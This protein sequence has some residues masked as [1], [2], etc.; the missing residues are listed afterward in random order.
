MDCLH[1]E[2]MLLPDDLV[3]LS[4]RAQATLEPC[5]LAAMQAVPSPPLG[6]PPEQGTGEGT[7]PSW[8]PR[9]C[10]PRSLV[11]GGRGWCAG[12][13][14]VAAPGR[15]VESGGTSPLVRRRTERQIP[16]LALGQPWVGAVLVGSGS[17]R[18]VAPPWSRGPVSP[19]TGGCLTCV[20]FCPILP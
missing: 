11:A 7:S 9:P 12:L 19:S 1:Q 18:H 15:Q 5:P 2:W 6:H 3:I 14:L 13:L 10:L 4:Y 8:A 17:C 16:R 20:S